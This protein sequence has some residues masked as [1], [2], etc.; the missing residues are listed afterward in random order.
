M[1]V[2][3]E[4]ASGQELTRVKVEDQKE[5]MKIEGGDVTQDRL[6]EEEVYTVVMEITEAARDVRVV[7]DDKK[8]DAERV[9][10]VSDGEEP[11]AGQEGFVQQLAKQEAV[12]KA[13]QQKVIDEDDEQG[14]NLIKDQFYNGFRDQLIRT[15]QMHGA[16]AE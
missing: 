15:F 14:H 2:E 5:A 6:M 4:E 1:I 9:D 16:G 12:P 8:C 10:V 7:S 11:P 3:V 13:S